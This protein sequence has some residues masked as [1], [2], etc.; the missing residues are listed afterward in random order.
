MFFS[1]TTTQIAYRYL[2]KAF[3]LTQSQTKLNQTTVKKWKQTSV[4][5]V[6]YLVIITTWAY[7]KNKLRKMDIQVYPRIYEEK[8]NPI[9]WIAEF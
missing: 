6:A 7:F 3:D 5:L 1:W 4:Q 8:H 9:Y 2:T